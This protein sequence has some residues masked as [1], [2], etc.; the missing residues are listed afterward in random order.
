MIRSMTGFA[1]VER[2]G[3]WGQLAWE[4]RSVNHRYLDVTLRL[5]EEV[6]ALE[7]VFRQKV[8][9]R[10]GRGKVEC[11]LRLRL[12]TAGGGLEIDAE[13]L[14]A[15]ADGARQAASALDNAGPVDP[16]RALAWPGVLREMAPDTDTLQAA[17][18]EALDAAVAALQESRAD[19]GTRLDAMLRE[20]A[21][22]VSDLVATVRQ[23]LPEV[24]DAWLGRLRARLDE[25]ADEA[26]PGRMEQELAIV[27][28]RMDVDEEMSRL[29]SHVEAF[30]EALARDEPVGRRLDFLMQEFNRE[31]NTLSS[32]SQ[33]AEITRCAVE[34]KVLIEQMREQVQNIE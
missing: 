16:L 7:S 18:G 17:A 34:M 20:R 15:L 24:R 29:L 33:D 9:D 14:A 8:S 21:G 6:R 28:Q 10:L 12:E 25:L 4:L 26:D 30:E 19:E 31:A 2:S 5:P 23:R 32:K 13:R 27:A 1:R 11:Q 3:D 22:G